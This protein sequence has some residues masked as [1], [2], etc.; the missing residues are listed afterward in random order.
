MTARQVLATPEG[1]V[2]QMT[3][4]RGLR[5]L[6]GSDSGRWTRFRILGL[7]PVARLGGSPDH[8][9]AAYGRYIAEAVFWTPAALLPGPGISWEAVD[10]R[11]A[12][13]TV[14]HDGLVQAVDLVTDENG[15][16]VQVAFYR[17]TD[18]NPDRV[19]RLQRFGGYLSAF[20]E[21]GGFRLPTHV[22]AGNMFGTSDYFP[23]YVVDVSSIRFPRLR[24]VGVDC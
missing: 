15:L 14:A 19:R 7:V 18:A 5:R 13:V 10:E 11:T 8:R 23:F 21:F 2:R 9:R 1:F 6:S 22:E 20:R 16:P 17:W 12:P 4:G 24:P 3:A